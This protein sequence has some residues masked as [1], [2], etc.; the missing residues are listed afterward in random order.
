[1]PYRRQYIH[2][3]QT[4]GNGGKRENL[5]QS[6]SDIAEG[7]LRKQPSST[8]QE[9]YIKFHLF[10][11][12]IRSP[13]VY[14]EYRRCNVCLSWISLENISMEII[15]T[16][17]I[18]VNIGALWTTYSLYNQYMLFNLRSSGRRNCGFQCK[19]LCTC[20]HSNI[21]PITEYFACNYTHVA[22]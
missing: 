4:C 14:I 5:V 18:N 13:C 1:M 2:I 12:T 9:L 11:K 7:N 16:N 8:E 3:V 15:T 10:S 17:L 22:M 6:Q 21:I 19:Y 20:Y